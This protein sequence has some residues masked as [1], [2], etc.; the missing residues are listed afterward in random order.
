MGQALSKFM[1]AGFDSV[2]FFCEDH[3]SNGGSPPHQRATAATTG[4]RCMAIL[5]FHFAAGIL[6][7]RMQP[8]AE[9]E[10]AT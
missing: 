9:K 4:H 1:L 10:I 7:A 6:P 3:P 8:S 5:L 2:V